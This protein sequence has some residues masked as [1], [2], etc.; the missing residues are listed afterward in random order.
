MKSNS[1]V[2]NL[3]IITKNWEKEIYSTHNTL[4]KKNKEI[5]KIKTNEKR[6]EVKP[7][8]NYGMDLLRIIAMINHSLFYF[9]FFI[10][11]LM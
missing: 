8:R 9:Y 11:I 1:E 10:F 4:D 7:K 2:S 6:I 5:K 3:E